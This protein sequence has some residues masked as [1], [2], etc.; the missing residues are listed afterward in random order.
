MI[1][2]EGEGRME[3][4]FYHWIKYTAQKQKNKKTSQKYK[5]TKHEKRLWTSFPKK[6]NIK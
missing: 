3:D 6:D 4:S 1:V 2:L 5:L